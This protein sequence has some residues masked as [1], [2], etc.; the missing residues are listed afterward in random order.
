MYIAWFILYLTFNDLFTGTNVA[1]TN[2]KSEAWF[3]NLQD[4]LASGKQILFAWQQ[5]TCAI[6]NFGPCLT[7]RQT[8]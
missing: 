2:A 6:V 5:K 8:K 1:L 3:Q 7:D 4:N